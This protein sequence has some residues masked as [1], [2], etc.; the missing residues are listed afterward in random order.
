MSTE[1]AQCLSREEV[2]SRLGAIDK[3]HDRLD[4]AMGDLCNSLVP[5]TA[6]QKNYILAA[7]Q[8]MTCWYKTNEPRELDNCD[9]WLSEAG[10]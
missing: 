4:R 9:F 10:Y 2:V 1:P 6:D 5:L 7:N 8:C 3:L